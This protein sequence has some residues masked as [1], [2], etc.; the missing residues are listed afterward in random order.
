MITNATKCRLAAAGLSLFLAPL[1]LHAQLP[2]AGVS[3]TISQETAPPGGIAQIKVTVTEPR[4]IS[5]GGMLVDFAGFDSFDGIAVMSPANDTFGVAQVN[6]SLIRF[7]VLSTTDS[8]GTSLDYPILTVAARVPPT[9]PLGTVMPVALRGDAIS[10]L[11]PTGAVYPTETKDGSVTV[12]RGISI[13][14]VTPGS[15]DLPAGS[16]VTIVG[17]GFDPGTRVRFNDVTLSAVRFVDATH[18]QVVLG[19]PAHMH[20]MRIRAENSAGA[21]TVYFSYQRTRRQGVSEFVALQSVVPLFPLQLSTAAQVDVRGV[22]TALAVQNLEAVTARVAVDLLDAQGQVLATS[23]L[24]IR[25]NRFRLNDVSELFGAPPLGPTS[26]RVRST[27]P[28]QVMGI[29]IDAAGNVAP[30]APR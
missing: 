28:I 2:F 12:N 1:L 16:V 25:S 18:M 7:T 24:K 20:G 29:A 3:L 5:T 4:P 21:K 14:D 6:G 23:A 27:V 15:A 9:T 8:F 30:I 11:S 13:D 10:L 26:L 22:S 17:R 19:A